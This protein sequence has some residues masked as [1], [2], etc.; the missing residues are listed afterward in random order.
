MYR[1]ASGGARWRDGPKAFVHHGAAECVG[2]RVGN[3]MVPVL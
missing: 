3:A 1:P 2:E